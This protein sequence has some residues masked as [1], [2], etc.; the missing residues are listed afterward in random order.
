M[1]PAGERSAQ[2]VARGDMNGFDS[3]WVLDVLSDLHAFS[4]EAGMVA[5]ARALSAT[6]E[7]VQQEVRATPGATPRA[8]P[9][10]A[11]RR[12]AGPGAQPDPSDADD[13][14]GA[15]AS[16]GACAGSRSD[17]RL[18]LVTRNGQRVAQDPA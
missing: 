17:T 14:A 1:N 18:R 16:A 15:C 5:S 6:F 3:N 2:S 12:A 8:A 13:D 4:R 10:A 7:I 9:R 11:R